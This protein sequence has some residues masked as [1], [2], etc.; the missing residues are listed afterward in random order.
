[1]ILPHSKIWLGEVDG[2]D[3]IKSGPVGFIGTRSTKLSIGDDLSGSLNVAQYGFSAI[4][5][6]VG[7][8]ADGHETG[9]E[10]WEVMEW[11]L[12]DDATK[13]EYLHLCAVPT[14]PGPASTKAHPVDSLV[15]GPTPS[16]VIL[17]QIPL[18]GSSSL[19]PSEAEA[20]AKL[21]STIN[22]YVSSHPENQK[23]KPLIAI[24][25]PQHD[26]SVGGSPSEDWRSV[27]GVRVLREGKEVGEVVGE[28]L[29]SLKQRET[30][31]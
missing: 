15:P 10:I 13:G 20:T 6:G 2:N 12:S 23:L 8:T 31:E 3:Q 25:P 14:V 18:N 24:C 4:F 29:E 5:G 11:L 9:T 17:F 27:K 21:I 7:K 22:H 19:S 1:M 16:T 30:K 28:M 26:E